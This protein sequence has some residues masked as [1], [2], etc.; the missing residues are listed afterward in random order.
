VPALNDVEADLK[1]GSTVELALRPASDSASK[2][3]AL[4]ASL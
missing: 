4:K 3:L 1:V 2:E